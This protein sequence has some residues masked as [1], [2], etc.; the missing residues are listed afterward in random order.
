[1]FGSLLHAARYHPR[2]DVDLAVWDVQRYY[3][4]V[5]RPLDLDPEI[6]FDLVPIEDAGRALRELIEQE[7]VNLE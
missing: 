6:S 7:G 5:S 3:R 2:S 4:A 1:V